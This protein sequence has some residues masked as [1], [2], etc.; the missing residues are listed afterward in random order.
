M[1]FFHVTFA[2]INDKRLWRANYLDTLHPISLTEDEDE[3]CNPAVG[4]QVQ[5]TVGGIRV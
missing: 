3:K 5:Q 1:Y 4:N 2:V